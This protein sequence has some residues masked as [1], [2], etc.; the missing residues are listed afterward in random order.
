MVDKPV[1]SSFRARL[2]A[3]FALLI[4]L[5]AA[6]L[7]WKIYAEYNN[8]RAAAYI[9]TEGFARAMGAHVASEMRVVDLSLLRSAEAL[10]DLNATAL[11]DPVRVRQALSVSTGVADAHFW[12]IFL[13]PSGTG[14]A[15]SNNLAISGV[16]YADRPYFKERAAACDRGLFVGAPE[17]GRV[18]KRKLF[19]LSR[20]VCDPDGVILGV[21]VAPVDASALA[22]VFFSA[23]FQPTLSI[24][25]LH[26]DGRLIAR[27]PLFE[28]SFATDLSGSP[29]FKNWKAVPTGS[30]AGRSVV[31]NEDR[32]FSYRTV[33]QLP[34]VIS[35]GIATRSWVQAIKKDMTAATGA[36]AIV[37]IAL[38]FSGRFAL[39]SFRLVELSDA[40]QRRLNDDLA[41]ARDDSARVARR[42]RTIAD[43]LP[44]LIAYIDARE[45]YVFHNSF[46]QNFPEVD[47]KR[48]LGH[49]M[50]EVL[51]ER[52]YL[53]IESEVRATLNGAHSVFERELL[54]GARKRHL[55]F[56]YTPDFDLNGSV[57]GFYVMTVD[58]TDAK[59]IEASLSAL[60]RV[61]TLTGLPNRNQVYERLTEALARSQRSSLPTG[62]LYLD[63]DH[64]KAINDTLG[65]AGGDEALRQFALRLR[66]C[67]RE[68]DLV[69]RLAGDEFVIVLESIEQSE[70]AAIVARKIIE[71]MHAPFIIQGV[72]R[73]VSTSIGFALSDTT[74]ESADGLLHKADVALYRAKREG[75]AR[76]SS[77]I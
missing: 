28:T 14:V 33:D 34:L 73:T 39:R 26:G 30:Y 43:G 68:T 10:D 71:A 49:S 64:F 3:G 16:S 12:V 37:A 5:L 52:F 67:V 54:F 47:V 55:K 8:A 6:L 42:L 75:K 32:V 35:V 1:F 27:A 18:S 24:T 50:R 63:I 29:L 46:Y 21:V 31:D 53:S 60:A 25:L 15:A 36:L 40:T 45:R 66:S 69:A 20:T 65:H 7:S 70:G 38:W 62:C 72:E 41:K 9:Q 2:I 58:V 44:A 48:M 74:D 22:A 56:D 77:P 4:G 19:F 61:D 23:M 76:A 51:G 13:D 57:V 17:I 59:N 11:K